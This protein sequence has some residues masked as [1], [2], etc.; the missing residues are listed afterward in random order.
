MSKRAILYVRVSTDEQADKGHSLAHQEEQLRRY[1]LHNNIEVAILY[2]EDHSAKT[3]ERPQFKVMMEAVKKK[4]V[5]ADLLLFLKWD[6]FSRNAPEAYNM[7]N[8]LSK[9]GIEPQG[10]EQPLNLEIPEQKFLLALYL[11]AP[12]VE[13]DRRSMN[14]I[15]GMRKAMKEGRYL[16]LAPFG[17]SHSRNEHN[18]PCIVPYPEEAKW[19]QLAYEMMSTG[20]YAIDELWRLLK[21]KGMRLPKSRF[22]P[23]LRNVTYIGKIQIQAY[24]QEA[25][26][27]VKAAHEP[28][29]SDSLFYKVQD[30][31]EGRSRTQTSTALCQREELPLRGYLECPQCG[32][33]L[34]GSG[35]RGRNGVYYYYHCTMGCRER[36]K[37]PQVNDCFL[38]LL[39]EVSAQKK[40]LRSLE[41]IMSNSHDKDNKQASQERS[42][43][44]KELDGISKRLH[45]AQMLMLDGSLDAEEYK[46]I[47]AKLVPERDKLT[48]KIT[49][50][51]VRKDNLQEII[52]FGTFYLSNLAKLFADADLSLKRRIIGSTFPE[53]LQF[54]NGALRTAKPNQVLSLITATS[55]G[56]GENKMSRQQKT[57]GSPRIG[58]H[59]GLEPSTF[60][61][62]IRC[63]NQLS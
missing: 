54:S 16:G 31:L 43:A 55:A 7:I 13:N 42:L 14:T 21:E 29:I 45:N 53:K 24:K 44:K 9:L 57:D 37:A 50:I 25:A 10:I 12:E 40:L 17:Y 36:V 20:H 2:R 19:V 58:R 63:S 47:K 28:I 41:L 23:L 8:Q 5:K 49:A 61:I 59:K 11:T 22:A 51:E 1:C 39:S 26:E 56:S 6:R 30:A 48:A 27:I 62:T 60:G 15:A 33:L 32:R 34:T 46:A 4:Q 35:S 18:R 3:F 38:T 52:E